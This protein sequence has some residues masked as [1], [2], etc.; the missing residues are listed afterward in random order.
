M[1][2]NTKDALFR[3]KQSIILF[4]NIFKYGYIF[5]SLL[6]FVI[7]LITKRGNFIINLVTTIV[8]ILYTIFEISTRNINIKT[9]RRRVKR[10]YKWTRLLLK[11]FI[12][13]AMVC[14][15][16]TGY[17]QNSIFGKMLLLF[18]VILWLMQLTLEIIIL[19]VSRI[20]KTTVD[21]IK[22]DIDKYKYIDYYEE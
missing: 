10:I 14:G 16:Y 20:I 2:D 21:G 13:I 8:F 9:T 6:Y 15:I 7:A 19:V 22:S 5:I 3:V 4:V 18:M 12:L 11:L 17:D 1:F